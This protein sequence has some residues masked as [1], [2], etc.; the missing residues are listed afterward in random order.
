MEML[1]DNS[2]QLNYKTATQHE[3]SE[4]TEG[5]ELPRNLGEPAEFRSGIFSKTWAF[6]KFLGGYPLLGIAYPWGG[7]ILSDPCVMT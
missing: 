7:L 3:E 4:Q 1:L 6:L 2:I 5:Y